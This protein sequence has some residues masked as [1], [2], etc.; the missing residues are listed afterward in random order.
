M[1][2]ATLETVIFFE[3]KVSITPKEMNEIKTKYE[4]QSL[5]IANVVKLIFI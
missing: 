5:V 4:E 2:E 3:K 1:T